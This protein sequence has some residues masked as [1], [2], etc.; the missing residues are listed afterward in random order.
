MTF[1]SN[2]WISNKLK[3]DEEILISIIEYSINNDLIS[4]KSDTLLIFIKKPITNNLENKYLINDNIVIINQVEAFK[5]FISQGLYL[6]DFMQLEESNDFKIDFIYNDGSRKK[7]GYLI[8]TY[9]DKCYKVT[10]DWF[11]ESIE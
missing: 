11:I 8:L 6:I 2:Y 4:S 3:V 7:T 9:K 5:N 1:Y 10:E